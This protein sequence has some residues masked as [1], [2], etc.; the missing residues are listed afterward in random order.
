MG[1]NKPFIFKVGLH[2]RFLARF[3]TR[4]RRGRGC[5]RY[6]L[7]IHTRDFMPDFMRDKF[8][9][10]IVSSCAIL[11]F[12]F[13]N[14]PEKSSQKSV[15]TDSRRFFETIFRDDFWDDFGL[16]VVYTVATDS[17]D[18]IACDIVSKNRTCKPTFTTGFLLSNQGLPPKM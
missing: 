17:R 15:S 12:I 5:V 3:L 7:Y 11:L 16:C 4:Q 14:R 1:Q 6:R 10:A 8:V 9:F 18:K 2:V 13:K